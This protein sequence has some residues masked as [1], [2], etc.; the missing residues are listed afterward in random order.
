MPHTSV[1]YFGTT[2]AF[3]APPLLALLLAGYDVRAVVL[4]A[5]DGAQPVRRVPVTKATPRGRSLPLLATQGDQNIVALATEREIP[6]WEVADLRASETL[7]TLAGYAPDALCVACF[8]RKLPASLLSLPRL[9]AL[10]VHPSLLPDNRGPDP[11]FWTFWRGDEATGVTIHLMD[12]RLDTGPILAQQ[13]EPVLD[14]M[15]E[16][17]LEARLATL[18]GE[19][20]VQSLGTL[21]DGSAHP[22]PQNEAQAT[23]FPWPLEEDFVVTSIWSARR[24]Y[25]F[26][27]GIAQRSTPARIALDGATFVVREAFGYEAQARLDTPWRLEGDLLTARL[28]PGVL[29]AIIRR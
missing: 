26:L 17:A 18:G 1:I 29:L 20:L 10:N 13:G 5:L 4:S 21:A 7:Q 8:A 3:S 16:A 9:G 25:R 14:G 11:L 6:V 12:E 23:A 27:R 24:A 22:Q 28:S 15:T 19:L 2:G